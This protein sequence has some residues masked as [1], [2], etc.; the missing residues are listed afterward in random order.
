VSLFKH[1]C[2]REESAGTEYT[3]GSTVSELSKETEI[4][5]TFSVDVIGINGRIILK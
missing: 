2:V 3:V 1:H 5:R 4:P